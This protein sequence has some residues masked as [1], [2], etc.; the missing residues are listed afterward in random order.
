MKLSVNIA[1]L[2]CGT[3][4]SS[5]AERLVH[6]AATL[7][8]RAGVRYE[9][10]AIAIADAR[11]ARPASIPAHLFTADARRVLDDPGVDLV[12]ECVGGTTDAAEFV[13]RSL[14][15]GRHVVTA[16]KD[17]LAT[18]GPRLHA[19]A[20]GRGVTLRFEA[21]VGG[22]IPVVRALAE[23]LA[24]DDVR[25]VAGV[26]NGTCTS[27]L[28]AMEDGQDYG[29]AL[30][31]AQRRGFAEADPSGDVD[32]VDAAHKLALLVQ[33]AF[34]LAVISPR[35]PRRGIGG[36]SRADVERARELGFRIRLVG[37]AVRADGGAA[38]EV[39][40]LLVPDRHSFAQTRGV[41]NVARIVA[42]DA[43]TLELRGPGA[44]GAATASAV[45]GDVVSALRVIGERHDLS[46]RGRVTALL[47]ALGVDALFDSFPRHRELPGYRV[48]TDE[49]LVTRGN[50]VAVR[51]FADEAAS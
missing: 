24:G 40:P 36:V 6:D 4:G 17:L 15:R 25:A 38:A 7:E 5:V 47:P 39:A 41:D 27:V 49:G 19:I 32:G 37:A 11:K 29:E 8:R 10:R 42:R 50:P 1:L 43:G 28:S 20:A 44:G 30:R 33:L 18:Q 21:A 2:G 34:G 16:N 9:L 45:L 48:W 3:V 23:S 13:E 35:I 26:F 22:A 14:A 51:A 31:D 46:Q 12:I